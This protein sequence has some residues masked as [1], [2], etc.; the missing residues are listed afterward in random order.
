MKPLLL[1]VSLLLSACLAADPGD[2]SRLINTLDLG[3]PLKTID[4]S[5]DGNFLVVAGAA[6]RAEIYHAELGIRLMALESQYDQVINVARFSPDGRLLAIGDEGGNLLLRDVASGRIIH[7]LVGHAGAI[8][9]VA[10]SPDG[11]YLASAGADKQ[12]IIWNL[13]NGRQEKTFADHLYP[14]TG[15]AYVSDEELLTA[16]EDHQLRRWSVGREELLEVMAEHVG[17]ICQLRW[18]RVARMAITG[19]TD[20]KIVGWNA[21][22]GSPKLKLGGHRGDVRALAFTANG[23]LLASGGEDRRLKLWDLASGLFITDLARRA[24]GTAISGVAFDP[25]GTVLV[26][27]GEDGRVHFWD[28]PPLSERMRLLVNRR[29]RQS[30][31]KK[32]QVREELEKDMTR[33]FEKNIDWAST[34]RVGAYEEGSGYFHV[35]SDLLGP[36]RMIV[37]PLDLKKVRN[38]LDRLEFSFLR[39]TIEDGEYRVVDLVAFLKGKQRRFVVKP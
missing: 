23:T 18:S 31:K 21:I 38:N 34:L 2:S 37:D 29:I 16:A 24:H 11:F 25:T 13:V 19:G 32:E 28:V 20:A 8:R 35:E 1:L 12:A 9:G 10:F 3:Y 15:V 27:C 4:F 7:E 30:G 14:L 39:M 22:T 26:S 17:A 5:A 36:L 33:F 6:A